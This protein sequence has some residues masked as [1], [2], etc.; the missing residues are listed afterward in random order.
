VLLCR[1]IVEAA[2]LSIMAQ[3][4]NHHGEECREELE[5]FYQECGQGM[6]IKSRE[7]HEI[8]WN[9]RGKQ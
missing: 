6:D 5:L 8:W 2:L 1:K 7:H 4:S 3:T 9:R